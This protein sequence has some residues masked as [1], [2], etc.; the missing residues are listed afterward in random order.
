VAQLFSLGIAATVIE[1]G[2]L[3]AQVF[4]DSA[5]FV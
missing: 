3:F 2:D 4:I 5:E 1:Y